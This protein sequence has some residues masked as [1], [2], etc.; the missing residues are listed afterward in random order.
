M[1]GEL[2]STIAEHSILALSLGSPAKGADFDDGA[3]VAAVQRAVE[4][5]EQVSNALFTIRSGQLLNHE[6]EST[7]RAK[8]SGLL[9]GLE[10]AGALSERTSRVTLL[11]SGTL[12]HR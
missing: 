3:F 9:L 2:Y 7:N 6:T 8:L 12:K 4:S 10:L 11:A 5:P 1:T